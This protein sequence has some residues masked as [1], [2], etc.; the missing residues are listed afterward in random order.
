MVCGHARTSH[1]RNV[2]YLLRRATILPDTRTQGMHFRL[3]ENR[4]SPFP[5]PLCHAVANRTTAISSL[6]TAFPDGLSILHV[7]ASVFGRFQER[8]GFNS[9]PQCLVKCPPS[10]CV[11]FSPWPS[12]A[13]LVPL[14][15]RTL[16]HLRSMR[17]ASVALALRVCVAEKFSSQEK[18]RKPCDGDE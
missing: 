2:V 12:T 17:T 6:D 10:L 8:S 13:Q 7:V 14:V 11:P 15:Q 5:T 3:I 9:R 18:C 1:S 16:P 4:G